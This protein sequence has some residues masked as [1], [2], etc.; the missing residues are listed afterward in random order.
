MIPQPSSRAPLAGPSCGRPRARRVAL[1]AATAFLVVGL[2]ACG[3]DVHGRLE[4]SPERFELPHGSWETLRFTV[5]PARPLPS[6]REPYLFVHLLGP[7]GVLRTFDQP[8]RG[9]WQPGRALTQEVRVYQS[10]VGPALPAGEYALTAGIYQLEGERLPL[11]AHGEERGRNEYQVATVVVPAAGAARVPEARFSDNFL[12]VEV[13]RDQQIL[14]RR[15]APGEATITLRDVPTAGTLWLTVLVPPSVPGGS[16]LVLAEGKDQPGVQVETTC[17]DTRAA[18]AGPGIHAVDLQL[19]SG[20]LECEVRLVPDFQ[21]VEKDGRT[22]GPAIEILAWRGAGAA[23][24]S[25]A[26]SLPAR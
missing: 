4:A 1:A 17:S 16:E 23:S 2:L 5:T 3:E 25:G 21:L 7:D 24:A 11:A 12:P 19:A 20:R 10:L 18:L 22:L 15:Y 6:G 26:A 14:A 9:S 13:G 8:L